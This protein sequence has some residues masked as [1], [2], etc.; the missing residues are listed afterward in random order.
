MRSSLIVLRLVVGLLMIAFGT[1]LV[2]GNLNLLSEGFPLG[3]VMLGFV[4]VFIYI[5]CRLLPTSE[6]VLS[7]FGRN[8]LPSWMNRRPT[9]LAW[10]SSCWAIFIFF[11]LP[12][13]TYNQ[14]TPPGTFLWL[15]IAASPISAV[16]ILALIWIP[17]V[18]WKAVTIPV[19][20]FLV[21]AQ[22]VMYFQLP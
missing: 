20:L 19:A 7:L 11:L 15:K 5:G 16:A 14:D 9:W 12:S 8:Q 3:L 18:G 17:R 22:I 10:L 21:F 13:I 4:F 1:L 2:G 6:S